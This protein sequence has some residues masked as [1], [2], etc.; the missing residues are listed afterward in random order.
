MTNN[1]KNFL[2]FLKFS[3][4]PL[5]VTSLFIWAFFHQQFKSEDKKPEE[6]QVKEVTIG[7]EADNRKLISS[8]LKQPEG[9]VIRGSAISMKDIFQYQQKE[10][11]ELRSRIERIEQKS[12]EKEGDK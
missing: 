11:D 6:V 12:F 2:G 7:T 10:L 4:L 3:T 5:I 9:N 1:T 8:Y